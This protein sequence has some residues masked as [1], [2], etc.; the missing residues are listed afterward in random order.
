MKRFMTDVLWLVGGA[1]L[2]VLT[3]TVLHELWV[4]AG[5]REPVANWLISSGETK[6]AGYWGL[7]SIH[8]PDW[9]VSA[10]AGICAGIFVERQPIVPLLMFGMGFV[11]APLLVSFVAGFDFTAFSAA[12]S[13]RVLRWKC[14]SAAIVLLFGLLSHQLRWRRTDPEAPTG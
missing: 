9:F 2:G 4:E 13:L 11:V 14:G 3:G 5:W 12:I 10:I 7:V 6:A 8:L 1:V